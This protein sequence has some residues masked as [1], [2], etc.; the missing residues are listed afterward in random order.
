M[1]NNTYQE[2]F[3]IFSK[4]KTTKIVKILL[5]TILIKFMIYLK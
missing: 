3:Y 1:E 5:T 4:E 2:Q